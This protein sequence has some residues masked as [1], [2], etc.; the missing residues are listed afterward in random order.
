MMEEKRETLEEREQALQ[1]AKLNQESIKRRKR[2]DLY[3]NIIV[4]MVCLISVAPAVFSVF[5]LYQVTG[6]EQQISYLAGQQDASDS[7][8]MSETQK[9]SGDDVSASGEKRKSNQN[10][11]AGKRVY[12]TFD[13]GPSQNTDEILEILERNQVKATFF[14]IAHT[15]EESMAEYKKIVEKGHGI[16]IHSYTHEY[17]KIYSSLEAFQEDVTSMSD[18]IYAATG[19]RTHLYRFPGGSSNTVSSTPTDELIKWLTDEGYIYYDWNALN[20]DAVT[21]DL[22]PKTLIKNVMNNVELN[23]KNNRTSIVLMHD[24]AVRHNTVESLEPLIQQLKKKGFVMD[25]PITED[26]E[27]IQ[28]KK[29][30]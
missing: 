17:S 28:Q 3:K 20:G 19:V 8:K 10:V 30:K 13:D 23:A 18:L 16:G 4:A 5:L 27:P 6:M 2:I 21:K 22:S 12:L 14:V 7:V 26:V 29:L 9:V 25:E 15:D 1:R 24:L 11:E